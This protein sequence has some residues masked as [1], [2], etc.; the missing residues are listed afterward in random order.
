MLFNSLDFLIFFPIVTLLYFVFPKKVRYLWLLASSYYF[1][2]CWNA[3][4]ALLMLFSTFV[5]YICSL[6]LER[7]KHSA[8]DDRRKQRRK[9]LIVLMSFALN[10]AVLGY[11]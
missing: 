4:Y 1:Y 6:L 3:K 10:L 9:K 7:V 2:M 8:L 11:F 5:T